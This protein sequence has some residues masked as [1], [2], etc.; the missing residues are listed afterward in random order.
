MQ[1]IQIETR[2]AAPPERCFL[3]SL[4]IDLHLSSTEQTR[5]RAVAGV[6][7]GLIGLGET[8]T[9]RGRHF[10]FMLAHE[11]QITKYDCPHYFQDVMV[12]G[13]FRSF[14]HDHFFESTNEERTLMRDKLYFAAP[15]GPL[16]WLAETLVLRRYLTDFLVQRNETIRQVAEAP[17]SIWRDFLP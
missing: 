6:T 13:V 10:G 1:V 17:E 7:H 4:S 16:G 9:W 3:L 8:V 11:T 12:R 5:E 15:L 14:E 2:I